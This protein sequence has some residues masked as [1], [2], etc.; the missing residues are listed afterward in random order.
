MCSLYVLMLHFTALY[1]F[2]FTHREPGQLDSVDSDGQA[3]PIDQQH[4]QFVSDLSPHLP[5]FPEFPYP[6]IPYLELG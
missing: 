4:Q 3:I 1:L 2:P 6:Q 5:S